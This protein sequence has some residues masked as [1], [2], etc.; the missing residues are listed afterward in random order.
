MIVVGALY[1]TKPDEAWFEN[2]FKFGVDGSAVLPVARIEPTTAL[3][4]ASIEKDHLNVAR[5]SSTW[6]SG[7]AFAR[8]SFLRRCR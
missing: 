3:G 8:L 2:H 4:V 6:G 1:T 7:S 5:V